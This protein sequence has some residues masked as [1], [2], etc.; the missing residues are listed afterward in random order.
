MFNLI[1]GHNVYSSRG[2]CDDSNEFRLTPNEIGRRVQIGILYCKYWLVHRRVFAGSIWK[3]KAYQCF[4]ANFPTLFVSFE[5]ASL[6]YHSGHC[7]ETKFLDAVGVL[8]PCWGMSRGST[9][10][11]SWMFA[12]NRAS[13]RCFPASRSKTVNWIA[14]RLE[15]TT[16]QPH[17][18]ESKTIERQLT[19]SPN[20]GCGHRISD[21]FIGGIP[22]D[23][24]NSPLEA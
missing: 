9:G 17:R 4:I 20:H 15:S 19:L 18:N 5:Q 16:L 3:T 22:W 13:G 14:S 21:A 1:L 23:S 7:L 10:P 24:S 2:Q 6:I 8:V 11:P 12:A